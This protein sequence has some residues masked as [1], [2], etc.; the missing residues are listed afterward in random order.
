[1][2]EIKSGCHIEIMFK[3]L[4]CVVYIMLCVFLEFC[5]GRVQVQVY[6]V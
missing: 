3:N 5:V 1:M 2:L 6:T 4:S